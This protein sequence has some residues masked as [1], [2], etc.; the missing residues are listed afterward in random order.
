MDVLGR[1]PGN[2]HLRVACPGRVCHAF[3]SSRTASCHPPS[4]LTAQQW[5]GLSGN[6]RKAFTDEASRLATVESPADSSGT[7]RKTPPSF[8]LN[9]PIP[10]PSLP[11]V[12][13]YTAV[14]LFTG[15]SRVVLP[16]VLRVFLRCVVVFLMRKT[17]LPRF[18][19]VIAISMRYAGFNVGQRVVVRFREFGFSVVFSLMRF[20][21]SHLVVVYLLR[22][23]GF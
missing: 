11:P 16:V 20:R 10:T 2:H 12:L 18:V 1:T 23:L 4:S 19:F 15:I 22:C 9:D 8:R 7:A 3:N 14:V 13:P 17:A 5:R 6:A 21:V